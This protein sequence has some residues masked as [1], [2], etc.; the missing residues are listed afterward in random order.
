MENTW[1]WHE[2]NLR[3]KITSEVYSK[4][5]ELFE[6]FI[7]EVYEPFKK[8]Q[9]S[10]EGYQ[11][12]DIKKKLKILEEYYK[13]VDKFIE[14]FPKDKRSSLKSQA[15]LRPTI[16]EEFCCYLFKDLP[17]IE[18]LG[19]GF[20][21]K[22]V[23]AGLG[24]KEDGKTKAKT[25]DVD[26]CIGKELTVDFGGNKQT[27]IIPI[28]AIECKTYVDK[29]MF[30]EAQFTAQSLKKGAP[31][32]RVYII[33]ERN[34]VKLD[35]IPSQTPIDQYFVLRG[36]KGEQDKPIHFETLW[37]FFQ[38]VRNMIKSTTEITER[39][40]PGKLIID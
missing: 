38:E 7:E 9:L 27:F 19:L 28:I 21:N 12:T 8:E 6:K 36:K 32:V 1:F 23:F 25:K 29:T 14:K 10:I 13:E 37:D 11:Q 20:F 33:S 40:I 5:K 31:N 24:I 3:A 15:K 26:C 18:K 2:K 34:E 4:Y 16:L 39:K 30:S 22:G 35:E 17:E